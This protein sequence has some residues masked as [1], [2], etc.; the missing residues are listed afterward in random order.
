MVNIKPRNFLGH[1][2]MRV[3]RCSPK[4]FL[5]IFHTSLSVKF[6]Y[7]NFECVI[8]GAYQLLFMLIYSLFTDAVSSSD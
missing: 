3:K 4:V 6:V 8:T 7:Q 1:L 5:E 2:L